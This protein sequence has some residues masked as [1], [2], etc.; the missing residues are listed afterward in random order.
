M[1]W[2]NSISLLYLNVNNLFFS[3]DYPLQGRTGM[4]LGGVGKWGGGRGG[5]LRV[6]WERGRDRRDRVCTHITI[7]CLTSPR[8]YLL[9]ISVAHLFPGS[10]TKIF[11]ILVKNFEDRMVFLHWISRTRTYCKTRIKHCTT[12]LREGIL[13]QQFVKYSCFATKT[14]SID[15]FS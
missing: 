11:A 2:E 10:S 15:K 7:S 4:F 12:R 3:R 9:R 6:F 14:G 8:L 13:A 5:V 1:W